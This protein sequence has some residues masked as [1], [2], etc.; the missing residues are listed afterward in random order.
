MV[1]K[2]WNVT[3]TF[4]VDLGLAFSACDYYRLYLF[5]GDDHFMTVARLLLHNT[6]QALNWDH[7]LYPELPK[8]LQLEAFSVSMPRRQGVLECL[9]WNYAAH[10]DPLIRLKDRFGTF[11]LEAIER[12]PQHTRRAL[13]E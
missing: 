9:S 10:L 2:Y 13:N 3:A 5:T 11:D 12:L 8:G 6:K 1:S 7:S 4:A